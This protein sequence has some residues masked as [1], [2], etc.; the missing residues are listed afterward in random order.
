MRTMYR[1]IPDLRCEQRT[2]IFQIK[3]DVNNVQIFQ[4][5]GDENNVQMYCSLKM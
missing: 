4:I 3:G 1:Y 2:D 5:N